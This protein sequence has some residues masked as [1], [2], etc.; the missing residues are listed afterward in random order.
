MNYVFKKRKSILL[1]IL[2][3]AI[4]V[5]TPFLFGEEGCDG[6]NEVANSVDQNIQNTAGIFNPTINPAYNEGISEGG[7]YGSYQYPSD[8]FWMQI[9]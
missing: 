1:G 3:I 8:I 9:H 7:S 4:M 5:C 2:F 6:L